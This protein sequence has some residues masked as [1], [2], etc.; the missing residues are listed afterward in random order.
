MNGR[1]SIRSYNKVWKIENKIYAIQNIV[2]PVPISPRA[3]IFFIL[4]AGIMLLLS[5]FIPALNR[6]PSVLR[7]GAFPF[8]MTQF[9]LKKKLDGKMP[10]KYFVAWLKHISS[11]DA[12]IERF[13]SYPVG[14]DARYSLSWQTG[15][16]NWR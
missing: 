12:Y 11:R 8:G 9:L 13:S 16:G 15:R 10:H 7:L 2:L 5:A 3:V 4:I 1:V 6:V 14:R